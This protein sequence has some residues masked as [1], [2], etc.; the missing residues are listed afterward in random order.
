LIAVLF[1]ALL[2]SAA[3]STTARA[4]VRTEAAALA[5]QKKAQKDFMSKKYGAG[6]T[7]LQNALRACGTKKCSD[8][9]RASLMLDLGAQEFRK[10]NKKGAT[11][12][13]STALKLVPSATL[14]ATYDVPDI[15]QALDDV[16]GPAAGGGGGGGGG[17]AGGTA[18]GA[19]TEP[20][21]GATGGGTTEPPAEKGEKGEKAEGE[22]TA[23]EKGEGGE[24]GEEKAAGEGEKPA[25]GGG[26]EPG[27]GGKAFHRIWVG[28]G[29]TFEFGHLPAGQNLCKQDTTPQGTFVPHNNQHYYCTWQAPGS[30]DTTDFPPSSGPYSFINGNLQ[31]GQAGNVKDS[32]VL[33]NIRFYLTLDYALSQ[34]FLVGTRLGVSLLTYPG[35][36]ASGFGPFYGEGRATYLFGGAP[37]SGGVAPMIFGG[38][39]V[40]EFDANASDNITLGPMMGGPVKIWRVGGPFFLDAGGG[41]RFGG[42]RV[43]GTVAVR[44]NFALGSVFTVTAGPEAG[45]LFGF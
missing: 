41:L 5:A 28:V 33:G 39:G 7:K 36:A 15:R 26:E 4:D 38:L 23:G 17:A 9:V 44:A 24:K 18:G 22:K 31:P 6:I 30:S 37:L 13:W 16:R 42:N 3:V 25:E 1:V 10:G 35:K 20:S 34:N 14:G 32:L 27:G 19:G 43:A 21:G 2:A 40:A 29:G 45:V 12:T 8:E 11:K